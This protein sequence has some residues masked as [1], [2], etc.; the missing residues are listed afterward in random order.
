MDI[1]AIMETLSRCTKQ[2]Y[3]GQLNIY[4]MQK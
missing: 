2:R 3:T 1:E 4:H